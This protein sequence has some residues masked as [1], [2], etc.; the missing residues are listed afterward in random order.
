M[1]GAVARL[2]EIRNVERESA[3]F[4]LRIIG[5]RAIWNELSVFVTIGCRTHLQWRKNVLRG[6]F[7]KRFSAHPLHDN[8]E[9][10]KSRVAVEPLTAGIKIQRLLPDD[11]IQRIFVRRYIVDVDSG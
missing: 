3:A 2:F 1:H 7:A 6:E 8:R 10:K 5:K 9:Q 11:E 4:F